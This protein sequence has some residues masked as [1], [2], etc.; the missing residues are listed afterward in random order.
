[1][2]EI[3]LYGPPLAGKR[4]LIEEFS[5]LLGGKPVFENV[6]IDDIDSIWN[7][8][9]KLRTH[10]QD[11]II[12]FFTFSGGVWEQKDWNDPLSKASYICLVLDP[13]TSQLKKN[14]DHLDFLRY[15]P[16]QEKLKCAILTKNDIC[17]ES[18]TLHQLSHKKELRSL[19]V[20]KTSTNNTHSISSLTNW[21]T[22]LD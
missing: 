20:F 8:S 15:S 6:G 4:T 18:K 19:P 22:D 11:K 3:A 5:A 17:T 1:M 21:L 7:V 9:V 13:Q 14:T 10:N 2:I 16:F 12:D